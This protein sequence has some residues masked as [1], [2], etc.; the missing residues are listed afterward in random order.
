M[1]KLLLKTF[2]VT[3]FTLQLLTGGALGNY[4]L[5]NITIDTMITLFS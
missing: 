3:L 4:F 2:L 5:Y 1:V